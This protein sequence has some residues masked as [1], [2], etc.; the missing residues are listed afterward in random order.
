MYLFILCKTE[1]KLQ[2]QKN[3]NRTKVEISKPPQK[4]P[5]SWEYLRYSYYEVFYTFVLIFFYTNNNETKSKLV[6]KPSYHF[7]DKP[8]HV[9]VIYKC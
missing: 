7:V 8:K 9:S 6:W 3:W 1:Q 4:L 5:N 2:F